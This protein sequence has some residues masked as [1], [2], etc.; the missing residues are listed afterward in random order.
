MMREQPD[1]PAAN[2]AASEGGSRAFALLQDQVHDLQRRLSA[3]NQASLSLNSELSVELLLQK[4][5][6]LSRELTDA[7][8]G[9]LAVHDG[10][11]QVVRFITAGISEEERVRLG[12][13]PV[14]Q[15]L[16]GV[17]IHEER[18]LRVRD[19]GQDPRSVGFP[20]G[21]PPMR[22]L[23]GVPVVF[24]GKVLGNLYV[25]DKHNRADFSDEDE[26][27]LTM[28]GQQAA[29]AVENA[30]LFAELEHRATEA[31]LLYEVG[32]I[33][34]SSLSL[35][36]ILDT[37]VDAAATILAADKVLLRELDDSHG[38]L[39][40]RVARGFLLDPDATTIRVGQGSAGRVA[41]TGR[42]V[43]VQDAAHEPETNRWILDPEGIRSFAHVPITV[44]GIIYGVFSVAYERPF[45]VPAD[46]L[47]IL[48]SLAD[49]AAIAIE[50]AQLFQQV[51]TERNALA[52]LFN[53]LSDG[54]YTTSL[55]RRL[56][57]VN[58]VAALAAGE[59]SARLEGRRCWEAFQY[60]DEAGRNVCETACPLVGYVRGG[61]MSQPQEVYL[62]TAQG[63]RIPVS[64]SASP[65][66]DAQGAVIGMVEVF[67]D[68][69]R[70][71]ELDEMKSNLIS[72]V[73]HELRTPLSHIKGFV[74]TL[75]Q[76]DV[77][78]DQETQR[79]FLETIERQADRLAK[80]VGDLLDMSRLEAGQRPDPEPCP[81]G[82]LV[83]GAVRIVASFTRD[84]RIDNRLP[85]DLPWV[86]ADAPQIERVIA[87][88]L[89]NAAKY[90]PPGTTVTVSAKL[91]E[92]QMVFAVADQGIGIAPED[93]SQI[94]DKFYRVLQ[95]DYRVP[96]TGLG[97]AICREII[98]AHGGR[99]WVES[100]PGT[101]SIFRFTLPVESPKE[102]AGR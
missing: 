11:G 55:E 31:H 19:V 2:N 98:T 83:A 59:P 29:I 97:L 48:Q 22:T 33:L 82:A 13:P 61:Q 7:R 102:G 51:T 8:Y 9:A 75:L 5:V 76:P 66:R 72:M 3:L 25:T 84:H 21:H 39:R 38:V 35:D 74:S 70:Q 80:L 89:E 6:D 53:S 67:R 85:E 90:S 4:I 86:R 15:G 68:I 77:A 64:L 30:R 34:N 69:R 46:A 40:G 44:G 62:Q 50:N 100:T 24:K 92:S 26:L 88:L 36:A 65:I 95:T 17:I 71:R 54:V 101:G 27:S 23:L 78:W 28:L 99:I 87:N 16:L 63:D 73:S 47:N 96:G 60:F 1:G 18:S 52:S 14:G 93:Q 94:F 57:R 45:A 43:I 41:G 10:A 91:Q 58:H 37:I 42:G 81:P 56:Q 49:Q 20:P 12:P 79:D 32:K